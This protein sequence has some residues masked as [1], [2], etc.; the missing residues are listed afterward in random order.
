M[1]R[2]HL[3]SEWHI[4]TPVDRVWDALLR[5]SDWP[6]WWRGIRSVE[7]IAPGDDAGIGMQLRQRWRSLLPYT[8]ELDLEIQHVEQR[9]L[10][11]GRASGDMSGTC[12]FTFAERGGRTVVRFEMDVRPAR[13][14]M[15]LPPPFA[16]RV[17][18]LN[19]D[20]IMRWGGEGLARRLGL[21]A[22]S[23]VRSRRPVG[24]PD[25]DAR[26]ALR[27][28]ADLRRLADLQAY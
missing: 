6:T 28:L 27:D 19:Y 18:A 11:V 26:A 9:R 13:A 16:G 20:A 15:N 14:W 24:S 21:E 2:Y 12:T 3:T 25:A 22:P 10:L 5:A 17:V 1:A 4:A 7:R 23:P 8:L